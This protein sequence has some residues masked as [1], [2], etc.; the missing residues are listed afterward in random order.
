RSFRGALPVPR[1]GALTPFGTVSL[2]TLPGD[3]DT[4]SVTFYTASDDKPTRRLREPDAWTRVARAFPLHA[5]W[6]DGEPITDT[7]SISGIVD[8]YRRFVVDGQPVATGFVA[9]ADASACTNPSAGRGLTVGFKHAVLL[10]DALRDAG[11][12]P[13][14]L[15][16]R[17]DEL[18]EAR[19]APWV[20]AQ[21]SW[22]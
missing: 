1:S 9:V 18:T 14:A 7:L 19:V 15:V 11:G 20:R 6:L 22:D 5:H 17:F 4:W 2:L 21:I 3:N 16:A 10:R 8:R 13:L 12:D